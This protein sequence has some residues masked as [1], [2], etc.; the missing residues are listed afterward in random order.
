LGWQLALAIIFREKVSQEMNSSVHSSTI[1]GK[2]VI[3]VH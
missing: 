1:V 2:L 3:K